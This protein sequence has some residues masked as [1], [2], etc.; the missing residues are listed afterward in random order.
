MGKRWV[1]HVDMDAFYAAVEQRDNPELQGKP[2][3]VGGLS[4]RGV[5]A[6]ASYEA[7]KFGVRSAMPIS[8]AKK[9]CPQGVFVVPSPE[10]YWAAS[11][12]VQKIFSEFSPLV[13]MLSVDEG[14]MDISGM[15]GLYRSVTE[16]PKLL[17]ARI[18]EETQ[19][20]AS[21]GV[22]PNKFVAKIASDIGKPNGLVI[23]T[24]EKVLDFLAPLPLERI[25][26]VGAKTAEKLHQLGFQ[27]I[28][29]IR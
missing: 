27:T 21:A 7:R 15:G 6:T 28:G 16:L 13:E 18:L 11:Q 25:W 23:V 22:G 9:R 8:E 12:K 19:L 24:H 4:S 10:R 1:M 2:V 5:V 17:R 20:V 26:G 3:I 29:D 14:F